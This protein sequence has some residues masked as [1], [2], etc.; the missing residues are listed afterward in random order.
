MGNNSLDHIIEVIN[1]MGSPS[2]E[3]VISM[4]PNYNIDDYNFPNIKKK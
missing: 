4:N 1:V 2:I 3:E